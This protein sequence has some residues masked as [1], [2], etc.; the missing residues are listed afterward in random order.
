MIYTEKLIIDPL[1]I[2]SHAHDVWDL[3]YLMEDK[4]IDLSYFGR[5]VPLHFNFDLR[6]KDL[7][8]NCFN[9]LKNNTY[10]KDYPPFISDG[11]FNQIR[12]PNYTLDKINELYLADNN[13]RIVNIN[14]NVAGSPGYSIIPIEPTNLD[15]PQ[16]LNNIFLI[17]LEKNNKVIIEERYLRMLYFIS[18]MKPYIKQTNKYYLNERNYRYFKKV[19]VDPTFQ[20]ENDFETHLHVLINFLEN[21]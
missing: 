18:E 9:Y 2:R 10:F 21:R 6:E 15:L 16:D 11:L 3:S 7:W 5:L 14:D 20:F 8:I 4:R 19:L 1:I 12:T 17:L 13:K